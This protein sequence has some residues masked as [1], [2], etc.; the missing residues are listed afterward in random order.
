MRYFAPMIKT[1]AV[2]LLL[3]ACDGVSSDTNERPDIV[4]TKTEQALT[5]D[6]NRFAFD[7]FRQVAREDK[8]FFISPLSASLA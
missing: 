1:V 2:L 5:N 6:A 7:L 4:L 3:S 8:N